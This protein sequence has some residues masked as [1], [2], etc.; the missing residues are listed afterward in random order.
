MFEVLHGTPAARSR[1]LWSTALPSMG[2]MLALGL[3][4]PVGAAPIQGANGANGTDGVG[5]NQVGIGGDGAGNTSSGGIPMTDAAA[6]GAGAN[7]TAGTGGGGGGGG[8]DYIFSPTSLPANGAAGGNGEFG[9]G[10]A[11]GTITSAAGGGGEEAGGGGGFGASSSNSSGGGGGGGGGRGQ[12]VLT[13]DGGVASGDTVT[14]GAGGNGGGGSSGLYADGGAGGGGGIGVLF[15]GTGVF[16]VSGSITGGA[17]GNGGAGGYA[18]SGGAGGSGL[19]VSQSGAMVYVDGIVL[20]GNGGASGTSGYT[21]TKAINGTGGAGIVGADLSVV[22]GPD[23]T[24]SGGL[25]GDALTRANA[26]TFTSGINS[27]ELQADASSVVGNVAAGGTDVFR[28]GGTSTGLSFDTALLG[29]QFTGFETFEKVGTGTWTLTGT[30]GTATAWSVNEGTLA[31]PGTMATAMAT[32][33]SGIFALQGGT[34]E[35]TLDNAGSTTAHGAIT[36]AIVNRATGTFTLDGD[37][38]A[39]GL[40]TNDGLLTAFGS[41]AGASFAVSGGSGVSNA[42]T[43][44]LSQVGAFAGDV[45]DLTDAGLFTGATGSQLALDIDLAAGAADQ[46]LL[47]ATTG[48]VQV[49]FSSDPA[50]YGALT[51]GV[52]VIRTADGNLQATAS[53]LQ[54]RGLIG[55]ALEQQG[56][57][58]YV[59]GRLNAAPLGGIVAGL[60]SV[61]T[62]TDALSRPAALSAAGTCAAGVSGTVQGGTQAATATTS[63][64]NGLH[65]GADVTVNYGGARFDL[66][67]GCLDLGQGDAT[68]QLGLVGAYTAGGVWQLQTLSGNAMLHSSTQFATGYAGLYAQLRSGG[69]IANGQLGYDSTDFDI[70]GEIAGGSGTIIDGQRTSAQRITAMGSIGYGY[71]LANVT[72]T[73]SA[74]LSISRT[75]TGSIELVDLGG[76]IDFA[77]RDALTAFG[78]LE[79]ATTVDLADGSGSIRYFASGMVYRDLGDAQSVTYSDDINGATALE[80]AVGTTRG[81]LSAGMTYAGTGGTSLGLSGDLSS[82]G[83]QFGAGLTFKAGVAF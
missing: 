56:T 49:S 3:V 20:G 15:G 73:P 13:T 51:D 2:L 6:A 41:G 26:I 16:S 19:R 65:A 10:G 31:L 17:G 54:D 66:D 32:S 4:S 53:G 29:N 39:G 80:T 1:L 33:G 67:F 70:T 60:H 35:G 38:V 82:W 57:D 25:N 50:H 69:F 58:W 83:G 40:I 74:G 63:A 5:S 68:I 28:L 71:E 34:L 72:L 18:G 61:Q 48:T 55:Y 24:I 7:G 81:T 36:G 14:G 78:G 64:S 23:G 45:L 43:I 8:R 22:L 46:L 30:P 76:R 21:P 44:S 27:F 47:G 52:L 59:T 77:D 75:Q 11:G 62:L 37:L 42:G 12:S 9:T 79:L